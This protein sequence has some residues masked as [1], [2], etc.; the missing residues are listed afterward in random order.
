MD[1]E[2]KKITKGGYIMLKQIVVAFKTGLND[3]IHHK[4][5]NISNIK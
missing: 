1:I 2:V 5:F 4:K 3:G